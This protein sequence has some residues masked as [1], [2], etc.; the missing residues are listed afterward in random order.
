M[1]KIVLILILMQQ[2]ITY[3]QNNLNGDWA[4]LNKYQKE[5]QATTPSSNNIVFMGDSIT[6]FW[7]VNDSS[8]FSEN[9]FINR[10]ISG[11][12]TSQMLHRFPQDVINLKPST[13]VILAGI[14]DIAENSGPI[15][16]NEILENI[17]AMVA[18]ANENHIKVILCSVLPANKF[19]W[20]PKIKPADKVIELNQMIENYAIQ[21]KITYVDYY[22]AMVDDNKGLQ[23]QYGEDGVHP[24]LEGYK[25]MEEILL[26][27]LKTE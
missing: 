19:N 5:N 25:V 1:K 13:V 7:K 22:S 20:N 17:K 23:L 27:Y 11:Q 6:E 26:P 12:T 21:N 14:N 4:N 8:F 9:P 18:L 2:N 16:L 10:G 3:S 15:T 24:N